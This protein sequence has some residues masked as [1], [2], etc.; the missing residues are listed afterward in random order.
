[1]RSLAAHPPSGLQAPDRALDGPVARHYDARAE[2]ALP[3]DGPA[4]IV[5]MGYWGARG[6]ARPSTLHE[7]NVALFDLVLDA[8]GVREGEHLLDAG[9]GFGIAALRACGARGAHALGVNVSSV[10]LEHARRAADEG[11]LGDRVRFLH[12]SVTAMP[13]RSESMDRI[14]SVEA[15][16]HFDSREAFFAEARRMLR[17]GGTI[18]IADL[19]LTPPRGALSRGAID[20]LSRSLAFPRAN[21]YGLDEYAARIQR[22]GLELVERRSIAEDVVPFFRSWMIR[23]AWRH[24]GALRDLA[25]LPYLAYPWDYALLVARRPS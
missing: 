6:G 1:M 17:P 12:A 15:A 14:V 2:H 23:N 7:A 22:A 4:P 5:N 16:F 13:L 19:V 18:A 20:S 3:T 9:C 24:R 11:G 8:V 10:Q 21:V 25:Q